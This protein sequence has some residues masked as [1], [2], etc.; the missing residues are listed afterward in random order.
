LLLVPAILVC[1]A[2]PVEAFLVRELE[3]QYATR[4]D[5]LGRAIAGKMAHV[6]R[7][8]CEIARLPA[9]RCRKSS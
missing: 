2:R 6:F 8:P 5:P 9:N 4:I 7:K 1:I 3:R